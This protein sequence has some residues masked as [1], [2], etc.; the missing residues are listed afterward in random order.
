ML[1][2]S[3]LTLKP[4]VHKLDYFNQYLLFY[5]DLYYS[6]NKSILVSTL[7]SSRSHSGFLTFYVTSA[8]FISSLISLACPVLAVLKSDHH[9]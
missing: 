9:M 5:D 4:R 2:L 1:F 8:Y 7:L 6:D 3:Y